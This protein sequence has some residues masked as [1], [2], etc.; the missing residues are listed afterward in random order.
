[1][2]GDDDEHEEGG[3]QQRHGFSAECTNEQEAL[4]FECAKAREGL[5]NERGRERVVTVGR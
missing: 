5:L 3:V 1:M 4:T 2:C